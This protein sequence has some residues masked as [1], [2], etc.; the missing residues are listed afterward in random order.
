VRFA[1]GKAGNSD[2]C[3]HQTKC[4]LI[5][6]LHYVSLTLITKEWTVHPGHVAAMHPVLKLQQDKGSC[7]LKS[8]GHRNTNTGLISDISNPRKSHHQYEN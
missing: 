3:E 8:T 5:T 4:L 7:P 2:Q 6:R 1:V